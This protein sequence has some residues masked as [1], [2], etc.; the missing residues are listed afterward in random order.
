MNDRDALLDLVVAAK[1]RLEWLR[2]TGVEYAGAGGVREAVRRLP[3]ADA[4]RPS[5]PEA[6]R[7]PAE[8]G[9]AEGVPAAGIRRPA[10]AA[11][12]DLF[13]EP[14]VRDAQALG[15]LR[16]AIGDCQRCKLAP[17]RTNLVFGVGNPA[18]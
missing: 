9:P 12:A 8:G 11:M 17:H 16:A 18:A 10:D 3:P 14:A 6:L 1:A 13:L 5:L 4:A 7:Q 15:E 2:E